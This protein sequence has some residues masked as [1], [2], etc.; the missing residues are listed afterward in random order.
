MH[1]S[2]WLISSHL[3]NNI[4]H[5]KVVKVAEERKKKKTP[6]HTALGCIGPNVIGMETT[7]DD[8]SVHMESKKYTVGV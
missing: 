6:K 2:S 7:N 5:E 8:V 4:S 3:N 1:I